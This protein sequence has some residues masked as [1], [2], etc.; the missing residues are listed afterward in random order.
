MGNT[1]NVFDL[2]GANR[3]PGPLPAGFTWRGIVALC[4]S[5]GSGVLGIATI[6]WYVSSF[7]CIILFWMVG[8]VGGGVRGL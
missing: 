3:P 7:L 2:E 4:F 1:E 8:E 5:V 6:A